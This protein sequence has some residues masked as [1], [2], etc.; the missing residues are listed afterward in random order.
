M[1]N[2]FECIEQQSYTVTKERIVNEDIINLE[3]IGAAVKSSK[4]IDLF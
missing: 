3:Y 1:N 2:I 4:I